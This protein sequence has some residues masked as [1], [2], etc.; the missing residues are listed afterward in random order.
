MRCLAAD[1]LHRFAQ[2]HRGEAMAKIQKSLANNLASISSA[3][4]AER[5][6]V[7]RLFAAALERLLEERSPQ[8]EEPFAFLKDV[9]DRRLNSA[10]DGEYLQTMALVISYLPKE[11]A[12]RYLS[13]LDSARQDDLVRRL[14]VLRPVDSMTARDVSGLLRDRCSQF[15]EPAGR[16]ARLAA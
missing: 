16:P 3:A 7:V 8:H 13:G 6:G 10:L 9:D 2:C 4:S 14:A 5:R 12:I 11:V 1:K 15:S